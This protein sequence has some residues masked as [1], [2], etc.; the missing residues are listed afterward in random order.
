MPGG[1][2]PASTTKPPFWAC[3]KSMRSKALHSSALIWGPASLILMVLLP[4]STK[5]VTFCLVSPATG[6]S[7]ASTFA[8]SNKERSSDPFGPPQNPIA[9]VG[10]SIIVKK[11]EILI[12]FPP[13]SI[14]LPFRRLISSSSNESRN[15]VAS[16]AGLRVTVVIM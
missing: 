3:S 6:V 5:T 11:R 10:Q 1:F 2:F 16:M 14:F 8:S 13:A 12:P 7:W 4:C 9:R 15:Q